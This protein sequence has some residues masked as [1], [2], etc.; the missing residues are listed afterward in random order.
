[1]PELRGLVLAAGLGVRL[2]PVTDYLPKPLLPVAGTPLLDRAIAALLG[3]GATTVAVNAHHRAHLVAAHLAAHRERARLRLSLEPRILGT[4]GALAGAREHLAGADLIVVYNGDVLGDLDLGALVAAHEDGGAAATLALTDWPAVNT[5]RLGSDGSVRDLAGRLGTP[6]ASGDRQLTF[7]GIACYDAAIL[8]RLPRGPSDLVDVLGRW[9]QE[10]PGAVRGWVHD[11]AWEDLGTLGRY[12]DAHRRLLGPGFVSG[13]AATVAAAA[14]AGAELAEVV[15]LPGATVPA[16]VRL[17]RA[18]VGNGWSVSEEPAGDLAL[19]RRAGFSQAVI[20]EPITGHGSDRRFLRL[21][22]GARRAVLMLTD[23]ADAELPRYLAIARFLYDLGLGAPA[24]LAQ[25]PTRHAVLLEDLGDRSLG[26]LVASE[27]R[28]A[29][30]L[31]DR[32][33]ARLA[34]LQTFGAE[35]RARCPLAWD[36]RFDRGHLRWETDYFRTRFLV[37]WAGLDPED[38]AGL[39]AEF[40]ALAT[41]ALAQP[42]TLVHRDFQSQNILLKDGVVRLVDVQGMRW[43]PQAY[44]VVSLLLDPYVDL[45][46]DLRDRLLAGFPARLRDRGAD[47][48]D[49]DAWRAMICV[50]GLQR[51]MQALGAYAFLGQVKGRAAFLAHIPAARARLDGLLALAASLAGPPPAPPPLPELCRLLAR[52]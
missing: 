36:R 45:P 26:A 4:A 46:A 8:D 42:R 6:A 43:G 19:A 33:L 38:C 12:L 2:R 23:A 10:R 21:R 5:V 41:A 18:V 11:G 29:A 31:Y 37:G 25:D 1:M 28:R 52:I 20:A 49:A 9:L 17:R 16:G 50:A 40:A 7:T 14:R 15:L 39:D 35:A 24:I 51:I 30:D 27:P 44:D 32:V 3:A 47:A 13:R 22:E 34:D 48:P